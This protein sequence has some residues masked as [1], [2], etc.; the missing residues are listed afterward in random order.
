MSLFRTQKCI[1]MQ[2]EWIW[3][4]QDFKRSEPHKIHKTEEK[5]LCKVKNAC[6]LPAHY[7]WNIPLSKRYITTYQENRGIMKILKYCRYENAI[8]YIRPR[9]GRTGINE[10]HDIN[11]SMENTL[12]KWKVDLKIGCGVQRY[13][14]KRF[15]VYD[16][17]KYSQSKLSHHGNF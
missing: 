15:T 12:S 5:Q 14:I 16:R 10:L 17:H 4:K 9:I 6:N 13:S 7:L 2:Y 1:M 8:H 3:K 11:T